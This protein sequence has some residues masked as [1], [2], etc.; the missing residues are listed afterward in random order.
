MK[1]KLDALVA[2]ML[3]QKVRLDEALEEVEKQFFQT[4]LARRGGNQCSKDAATRP[5][6]T[7]C[8]FHPRRKHCQVND[9]MTYQHERF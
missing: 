6:A 5:L 1:E 4:A 7:S 9:S 2:E 8:G 3:E